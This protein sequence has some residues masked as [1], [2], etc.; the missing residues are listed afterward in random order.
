MS[1]SG[2]KAAAFT[3]ETIV[4][5]CHCDVTIC[6]YVVGNSAHS[7]QPPGGAHDVTVNLG[8]H[9]TWSQISAVA[10]ATVPRVLGHLPSPPS[11]PRGLLPSASCPAP[12][13][14]V[15]GS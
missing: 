6:D 5:L 8:R 7:D 9:E 3:R 15:S 12:S 4:G 13:G 10:R 11:A 2:S 1:R 14:R